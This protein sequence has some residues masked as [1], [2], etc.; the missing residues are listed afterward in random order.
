MDCII[1]LWIMWLIGAALLLV[2]ELLTGWIATFCVGV[3]CIVASAMDLS[4]CSFQWQLIGVVVGVI[5][6]FIFLAPFVNRLRKARAHREAYNSN[7]DALIG[8]E[9]AVEA[10]IPD[11]ALGRVRIDGDS[12]Q[13]RSH[14]GEAIESGTSV[15]VTG[16]DSIILIV[17]PI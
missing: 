1:S 3:G 9:V 4:G 14:N 16:Y 12:W 5:L 2:I 7:M 11:N 17:K 13:A 10:A 6:A 8:R 15:K